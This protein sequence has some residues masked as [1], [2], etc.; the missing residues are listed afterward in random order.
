MSGD[1]GS[2]Y[3]RMGPLEGL[4]IC[5]SCWGLRGPC[6]PPALDGEQVVQQ[7][8]CEKRAGSE[9]PERWPRFDFN[10]AVELCRCC[11]L[12][13]LPSG[14]RWSVWLCDECQP[15]ALALNRRLGRAAVPIGRHSMMSGIFVTANT[16]DD[17]A[18]RGFV[19]ASNGMFRSI[20]RLDEWSHERVAFNIDR[21]DLAGAA[22]VRLTMYLARIAD[23]SDPDLIP[24]AAFRALRR[25]LGAD[26]CQKHAEEGE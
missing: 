7:C 6:S 11:G 17:D 3:E 15:R 8:A 22:P 19:E 5:P 14:S 20:D 16:A 24:E 21:L 12:V 4:E 1:R 25:H 10:M 18:I 9:L 23:A 2:E 26:S 13:P